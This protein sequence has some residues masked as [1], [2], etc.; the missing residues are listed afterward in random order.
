MNRL[1]NFSIS[2]V[3]ATV[4]CLALTSCSFH[5]VKVQNPVAG[6]APVESKAKQDLEA[7]ERALDAGD[8]RLARNYV[9]TAIT[10]ADDDSVMGAM[11]V[12]NRLSLGHPGETTTF[13]ALV[14]KQLMTGGDRDY[15]RRRF[16]VSE[17][18]NLEGI[19]LNRPS[20]EVG[21]SLSQQCL[22]AKKI[23]N[24][25]MR[26]CNKQMRSNDPFER[27]ACSGVLLAAATGSHAERA[28]A[29]S[30]CKFSAKA[31]RYG[32]PNVWSV[33]SE[34]IAQKQD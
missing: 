25:A 19:H 1:S 15:I 11:I 29:I 13:L 5:A 4:A 7:A 6:R 31:G 8:L 30:L 17:Y 10:L 16:L 14:R 27:N 3:G 28:W 32:E 33:I 20:G 26:F 9:T 12:M 18:A 22:T 34:L 2:I 24:D 23:T 21:L